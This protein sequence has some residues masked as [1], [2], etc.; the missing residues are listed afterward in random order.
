MVLNK[1]QDRI[2]SFQDI[3]RISGKNRKN[4]ADLQER[5]RKS[6]LNIFSVKFIKADHYQPKIFE[7]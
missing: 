3:W 4:K 1:N 5:L 6:M 2:L 7:R